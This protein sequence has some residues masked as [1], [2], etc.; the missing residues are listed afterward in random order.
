MA[1]GPRERW[2]DVDLEFSERLDLQNR[3]NNWAVTAGR[4][5]FNVSY[6]IYLYVYYI[7]VYSYIYIH[8][9]IYNIYIVS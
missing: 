9:H 3:W 6:Y 1:A 8:T 5:C 2:S 7:I 4:Q